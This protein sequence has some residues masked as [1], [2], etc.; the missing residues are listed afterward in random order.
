MTQ[1][2]TFVWD[3]KEQPPWNKISDAVNKLKQQSSDIIFYD[4]ETGSDEYSL[5][6]SVN[7]YDEDEAYKVWETDRYD[8]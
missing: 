7:E 5:L 8:E 4:I 2:Y 3:W 6:I 1:Y